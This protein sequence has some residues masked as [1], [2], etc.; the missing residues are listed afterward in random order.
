VEWWHDDDG[1]VMLRAQL[2]AE[3]GAVV[4]AA[5]EA[6]VD[7]ARKDTAEPA[8]DAPGQPPERL[9]DVPAET[10]APGWGSRRADALLALT[11]T[12]LASGPV[13][14][15][16]G[17]RHQ[18][19]VHVDAATLRGEDESGRSELD[20][21]APLSGDTVRRLACDASIVPLLERDRRAIDVGRKTRAIPPA[22]QRALSARDRGCRFPG[23]Q[24]RRFVDA[25]HLIHW[26]NGGPTNLANLVQLCRHHHRLMHEGGYSLSRDRAGEPV[27]YRPDGR[28]IPRCPA[29]PRASPAHRR[30][31]IDH[32]S[33]RSLATDQRFDMELCI[34]ALLAIAPISS[35]ESPGI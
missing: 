35:G 23:C 31:G 6:A 7:A 20:D 22:L 15:S 11:D 10:P 13:A 21:G 3:E 12:F 9:Q 28:P 18:V 5:I 17:D 8:A 26:A 33:C 29:L 25:H 32:R 30:P 14:R 1:S 19:V 2:P 4:I 16:G 34:Q 27:F 24:A